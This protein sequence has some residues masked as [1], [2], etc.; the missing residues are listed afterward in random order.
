MKRKWEISRRHLL[1]GLGASIALP[2]LNAM[3][4]SVAR[5]ENQCGGA[6]KRLLYCFNPNGTVMNQFTPQQTGYD[7]APTLVTQPLHDAGLVGEVSILS[8]IINT[9]GADGHQQCAGAALTASQ[10]QPGAAITVTDS[11][12]QV[13][14][15]A[16]PRLPFRSLQLGLRPSLLSGTAQGFPSAYS[17]TQSF[18]GQTPLPVQVNPALVFDRLFGASQHTSPAQYTRRKLFNLSVL[19]FVANDVGNL[20]NR[21][22][23]CDQRRLDEY[24]TGVRELETRIQASEYEHLSC[25]A[26]E[27]PPRPNASLNQE[28]AIRIMHDIIVKAFQCDL[29]RSIS[30]MRWGVGASD[31]SLSYEHVTNITTGQPITQ[32]YHQ[33]SHYGTMGHENQGLMDIC[34]SIE[35]WEMQMFAELVSKL[36]AVP[37]GD[38]TLLDNCAVLNYASMDSGQYHRSFSSLPLVLAGRLAGTLSPGQHLAFEPNTELG[39]LHL[40]LLRKSG[41]DISQFGETGREVLAAL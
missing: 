32:Q 16:C 30:F 37:E 19:D 8:N 40:T 12:D 26:G 6:P 29:T 20:K 17:T 33:A 36:R 7:W 41:V 38:G 18:K 9:P 15:Q 2:T 1:K 11:V 10:P 14:A 13:F 21:L 28:E 23:S 22:G 3:M 25:N 39:N 5:A 31:G 34:T 24:L 27:R 4:P 35:R